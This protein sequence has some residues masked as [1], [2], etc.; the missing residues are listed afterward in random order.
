MTQ[1]TNDARVRVGSLLDGT[2]AVP[3]DDARAALEVVGGALGEIAAGPGLL[4]ALVTGISGEDR[5]GSESYP[6]MDKLVL[7]QS[8]DR[9][10]RLRLHLFTPGYTDRPHNHR[11]CFAS[12]ILHG[13]YVQSIYGSERDV[14][15]AVRAGSAV[16][17]LLTQEEAAG[18]RYFLEHSLVHSLHT[19]VSTVS[20]VLRGP[21]VKDA[22]FTLEGGTGQP[23]LV[24]STGT[25]R[26]T[27][28]ER[29]SKVMT[30]ARLA[31]VTATL[32]SL[33]V[34]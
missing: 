12:R 23:D 9:R 22:Y 17:P 16:R 31:E 28:D 13:R 26:E 27:P 1:V 30:A 20:L 7:W 2:G 5:E 8:E 15:D 25:T 6:R 3:W 18:S 29:E 33:G 24:L 21:A 32:R 14:L 34:V 4:A 11:W 19:D 10:T